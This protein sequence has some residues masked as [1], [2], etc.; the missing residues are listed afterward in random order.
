M[1]HVGGEHSIPQDL[2]TSWATMI[3]CRT[4]VMPS[5]PASTARERSEPVL[6]SRCQRS[7]LC[8]F[9]VT[10][11]PIGVA[12]EFLYFIH[13]RIV[14]HVQCSCIFMHTWYLYTV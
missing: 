14:V 10:N 12:L 2:K 6:D 8:R 7:G 9:G 1:L 4:V 3:T 11:G 13:T 5:K